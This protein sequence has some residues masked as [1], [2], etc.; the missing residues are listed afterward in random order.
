MKNVYIPQLQYVGSY[1]EMAWK[2]IRNGTVIG[3]LAGL[4]G[5]TLAAIAAPEI[6]DNL[7]GFYALIVPTT[8]IGTS[9]AHLARAPLEYVVITNSKPTKR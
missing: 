8:A 5:T 6:R 1:G 2:A 7:L 3:G 9:L 4:V